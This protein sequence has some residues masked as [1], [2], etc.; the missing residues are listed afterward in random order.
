ML[1]LP[2]QWSVIHGWTS[3]S[4]VL[5]RCCVCSMIVKDKLLRIFF[6]LLQVPA[7]LV[8]VDVARLRNVH[9][10]SASQQLAHT[11]STWF[12]LNLGLTVTYCARLFLFEQTCLHTCIAW[13]RVH[14]PML[15]R[16]SNILPIHYII[17]NSLYQYIYNGL[18][19]LIDFINF[20]LEDN[21]CWGQML[22]F[23]LIIDSSRKDVACCSFTSRPSI[24]Y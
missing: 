18:H 7:V 19:S 6:R 22:W 13:K 2:N 21:F 3:L 5:G 23:N 17:T 14:V 8:V 10:S 4:Q 12:D 20:H 1:A 15:L 16:S 11:M 9:R 24:H